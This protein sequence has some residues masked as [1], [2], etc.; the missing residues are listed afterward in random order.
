MTVNGA[1]SP[2]SIGLTSSEILIVGV[3]GVGGGG[4]VVTVKECVSVS[5]VEPSRERV[6]VTVPPPVAHP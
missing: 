1:L 4:G 2:R 6:A 5:T 3:G